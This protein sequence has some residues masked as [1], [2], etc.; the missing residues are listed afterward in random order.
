MR[1]KNDI[2]G[3]IATPAEGR[4]LKLTSFAEQL[5]LLLRR[6]APF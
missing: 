1:K 2:G 5:Q 4:C 6:P 3:N